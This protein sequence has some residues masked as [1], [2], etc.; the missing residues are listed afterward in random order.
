MTDIRY[1]LWLSLKKGIGNRVMS[2]LLDHFESPEAVFLA[3]EKALSSIGR[4]TRKERTALTDKSMVEAERVAAKCREHGI[5][6]LTFDNPAYP[7][8]LKE[9]YDPPYVLYVRCKERIDLNRHLTLAVVGTRKASDY[10]IDVAEKL[11]YGIA[12]SGVT[13]VSGMALGIDGAAQTGALRAGGKTIAVLGCG[14]DICY[15][16]VHKALMEQIIEHG[17]V[18][19]EHP[20]GTQVH[21]SHFLPRN[22]IITGLSYGTLVVEAPQRS[23][24]INSANWTAQQG[25]ELFVV[26]GD[27][28]RVTAKGSNQLMV[29]GALPVLRA[30]DITDLYSGRFADILLANAPQKDEIPSIPT[31]PELVSRKS[32]KKKAKKEKTKKSLKKQTEK[33]VKAVTTP[34]FSA[35]D[36]SL[37]DIE[38]SVLLLLGAEPLHAD[39]LAEQGIPA[40]S[41]AATLT[42][43][44]LKGFVRS[45]PG[46]HY[47]R[48]K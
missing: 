44:E 4:L 21:P 17:M 35:P 30:E 8:L 29:E 12:K 23:G 25:R 22:R 9:I 40:A 1:W 2:L 10:G 36:S 42:M 20:P 26:P 31:Y 32:A 47:I 34:A 18:I 39:R 41:V 11:A 5:R 43:L 28:T 16:K 14:V 13:V 24:A 19:S 7:Q 37:S 6:I 27:V 33:V 48:L 38:K 45:L 3:D 46:K 15:P